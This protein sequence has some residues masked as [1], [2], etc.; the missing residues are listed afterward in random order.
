MGILTCVKVA[1][2]GRLVKSLFSLEF[3]L[4]FDPTVT[5]KFG[6]VID[7]QLSW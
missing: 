5:A 7:K 3:L 6:L 4:V 2:A 1:A